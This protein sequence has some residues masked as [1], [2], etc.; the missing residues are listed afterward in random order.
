MISLIHTIDII[1]YFDTNIQKYSDTSKSEIID[2]YEEENLKN[3]TFNSESNIPNEKSKPEIISD[4][5]IFVR[6]EKIFDKTMKTNYKREKNDKKLAAIRE[7][8]KRKEN[9]LLIFL[10]ESVRAYVHLLCVVGVESTQSLGDLHL[11][12]KAEQGRKNDKIGKR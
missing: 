2:T 3:I 8:N 1:S 5:N 10:Q 12:D 9:L 4:E 6:D 11:V 7:K